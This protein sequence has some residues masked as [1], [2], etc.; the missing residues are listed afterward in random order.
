MEINKKPAISNVLLR[1]SLISLVT[2]NLA[3]LSLLLI[4]CATKYSP[5]KGHMKN[6]DDAYIHVVKSNDPIT[7][8]ILKAEP[9]YKQNN[10]KIVKKLCEDFKGSNPL[11]EIYISN[12]LADILTYHEVDIERAF[13]INNFILNSLIELSGDEKIIYSSRYEKCKYPTGSERGFM[14][15][16]SPILAAVEIVTAPSRLLEGGGNAHLTERAV[17][18]AKGKPECMGG[19]YLEGTIFRNKYFDVN[20]SEIKRITLM[21]LV[22][23]NELIGDFNEAESWRKQLITK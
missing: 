22:Y 1:R 4:S 15:A 23:L 17:D 12:L 5:E 3:F 14:T 19:N 13:S 6:I 2:T 16:M 11:Q 21:R 10:L 18:E 9:S 20:I 7:D 8:F